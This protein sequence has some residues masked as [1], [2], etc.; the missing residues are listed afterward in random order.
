MKDNPENGKRGT[1][2][3]LGEFPLISRL[4]A[5]QEA[6]Q[7]YSKIKGL[8]GIGD[9]AAIIPSE[10]FFSKNRKN[11]NL[12]ISTD[13]MVENKHFRT[14]YCKPFDLG[15]KLAAV[16]LSDMAACGATPK[17]VVI[18]LQIKK[19]TQLSFVDEVYKGIAAHL[20]HYSIPIVG[21]D[22]SSGSEIAL[23]MTIFGEVASPALLRS[24]AKVGDDIW[25]SGLLGAASLGFEILE[26]N[27]DLESL[28]GRDLVEAAK[29]RFFKPSVRVL[30]A[31]K[32]LET[33][34]SSCAIDIS[35]GLV[36]DLKHVARASQVNLEIELDLI[37]VLFDHQNKQHALFGGEDYEIVFTADPKVRTGLYKFSKI[38]AGES[39]TLTRI[40]HVK[41]GSSQ[42]DCFVYLRDPSGRTVSDEQLRTIYPDMRGSGYVHFK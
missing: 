35:D 32:L 13:V 7:S 26:G 6:A 41:P 17:A 4:A 37:P 18:T 12:A 24:A 25:V 39:V 19:E 20:S 14:T 8:I 28:L 30:L 9:D 29:E 33:K 15:W 21:G 40:G 11:S 22:T 31:E 42:G 36:Q 1:V 16:N 34:L 27:S 10:W 38:G 2:A 5:A 23:G 3:E